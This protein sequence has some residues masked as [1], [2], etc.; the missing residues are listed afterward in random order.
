M[1]LSKDKV[2]VYFF[3]ALTISIFISCSK[4][5][6]KNDIGKV[7][8]SNE[9]KL[10]TK[11]D[12][13]TIF[14]KAQVSKEL[15]S[16]VLDTFISTWELKEKLTEEKIILLMDIRGK[17]NFLNDR[18]LSTQSVTDSIWT[19][20]IDSLIITKFEFIKTCIY[21]AAWQGK[22][23]QDIDKEIGWNINFK[24]SYPNILDLYISKGYL[25][26]SKI[27]IDIMLGPFCFVEKYIFE[28]VNGKWLLETHGK[29]GDC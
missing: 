5:G 25:I 1:Q 26:D 11:K 6:K 3:V 16:I 24:R 13:D 29:T 22:I 17:K 28:K 27:H 8:Q 20:K 12:N 4:E 14:P 15:F 19:N 18:F 9:I 23:G 21:S 10:L 2:F 7:I